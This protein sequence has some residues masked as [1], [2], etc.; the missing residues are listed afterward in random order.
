MLNTA[1]HE[2]YHAVKCEMPTTVWFSLI[3]QKGN[4]VTRGNI[5][6]TSFASLFSQV[7]DFK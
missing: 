2:L 4:V 1:E 5:G 7:V 3:S 6:L